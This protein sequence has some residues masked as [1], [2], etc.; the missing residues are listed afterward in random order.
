MAIQQAQDSRNTG[1]FSGLNGA[2]TPITSAFPSY[3]QL[4]R[5]VNYD[6][7]RDPRVRDSRALS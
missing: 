6:E 1:H 4:E 2:P 5:E 3:G 7:G